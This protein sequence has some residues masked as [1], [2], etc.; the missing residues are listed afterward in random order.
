[1]T[2]VKN[3]NVDDFNL[4]KEID[5]KKNKSI[6]LCIDLLNKHKIDP[7][8]I[9]PKQ[10]KLTVS[11]EL[12]NS[13]T[14]IANGLR[15][16]LIDEIPIKSFDLNEHEDLESSDPYILCDVIK[17]QIE[18]LPINQ[19]YDYSNVEIS[20]FK[21][22]TTDVIIDVTT[23]DFIYKES[24]ASKLINIVGSGI[25]LTRLRPGETI[26]IKKITISTGVGKENYGKFS[27]VSNITYKILDATP[28]IDTRIGNEGIS[29]MNSNPKHF[30]IEYSTHRNIEHPLKL[31]SMSCDILIARFQIIL[32]DIKNI[33]NSDK[34][35]LSDL[36]TLETIDNKK[37]L[38]IKGEYWTLVNLIAR[39]CYILT[40][41]NIQFVASAI[42]H[43]EKEV[44][45]INII[46]SEFSSLL[47]NSIKKIIEEYSS[48]K[49][50]FH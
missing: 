22:N 13:N 4:I 19:E 48:I 46:H 23:D 9:L 27:S 12:T 16:C 41:N 2:V 25:L 45:V 30:Y 39:Y 37:V 35:Y 7:T 29:S 14:D 28:M 38:K 34:S 21:E 15:R 6:Q 11:F 42:I 31:V 17:K 10:S 32:D 18:L 5:N 49:K 33:K 20:L 40:N 36:L 26:K 44:G 43:P 1:M 24:K 8:T 47:S 3:I 50:N